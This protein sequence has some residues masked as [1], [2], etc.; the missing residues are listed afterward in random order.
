MRALL[1]FFSEMGWMEFF[2]QKT[3][4][5]VCLIPVFTVSFQTVFLLLFAMAG[6]LKSAA[7]YTMSAGLLLLAYGLIKER[8]RALSAWCDGSM[9]FAM[10]AGLVMFFLLRGKIV[11]HFDNFTHWALIVKHL[12]IHDALPTAEH[13]VI[14]YTNY[15]VGSALWIYY[16]VFGVGAATEDIWLL[17]QSI[18]MVFCIQTLFVCVNRSKGILYVLLSGLC[19]AI[20]TNSSLSS[21]V[22]IYNLLV[23]TMLPLSALAG[24][25]ITGWACCEIR[26][27]RVVCKESTDIGVWCAVPLL[28]MTT[29]IKSSGLIFLL[30]PYVTLLLSAVRSKRR[31]AALKPILVCILPLALTM[32]W[33]TRHGIVFAG[34]SEG[35]HAVSASSFLAMDNS[36]AASIAY[37]VCKAMFSGRDML[38]LLFPLTAS[39]VLMFFADESAADVFIKVFLSI[40]LIYAM[41]MIGMVGMYLF[42][43]PPEEAVRL[44]GIDR[45]RRSMLIWIHA[46]LHVSILISLSRFCAEGDRPRLYRSGAYLCMLLCLLSGWVVYNWSYRRIKTVADGYVCDELNMRQ[47]LEGLLKE[48]NIPSGDSYLLWL[49]KD[50]NDDYHRLF[51]GYLMRYLTNS[52]DVCIAVQGEQTE[53]AWDWEIHLPVR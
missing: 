7:M 37:S 25:L 32:A 35:R 36:V 53:G 41:Y 21:N 42:A 12:L 50:R 3:K 28:C 49:P 45:Y 48:E 52:N 5:P 16:F 9:L 44:A 33:S 39:F 23:D 46:M 1:F 6:V 27:N 34:V 20:Y 10:L 38:Y 17:A 19:V 14:T 47:T 31:V 29:Q 22:S 40:A 15:P 13:A 11:G 4:L 8:K 2:R 30:L 43:M 51:Y 26:E 24:T 18:Y